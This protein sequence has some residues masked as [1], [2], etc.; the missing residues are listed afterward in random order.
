[1]SDRPGLPLYPRFIALLCR[2]G[3]HGLSDASRAVYGP[4]NWASPALASAV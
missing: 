4:Y 1:M 2:F 3:L